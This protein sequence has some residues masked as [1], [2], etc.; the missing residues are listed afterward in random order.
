LRFSSLYAAAAISPQHQRRAQ[1]VTLHRNVNSDER[2]SPLESLAMPRQPFLPFILENRGG[3]LDVGTH[4]MQQRPDIELLIAN[5]LM[6]WPHAEAQMAILL[7]YLLGAQQ[8]EAVLAVFHSL[9]RSSAQ[10]DAISEAARFTISE[11]DQELLSAILSAHKR[12]ESERNAL[13]HGH[14]GTYSLLPDGIV[15]MD[16][17]TF[18]DVKARIDLGHQIPSQHFL[19]QLYDRTY[20]YKAN[21]ISRTFDDIKD[22]ADIWDKFI[23][24]LRVGQTLPLSSG[25]Y[26]QLC[27]RPR[28]AQELALLRREKTP[29]A[30]PESPQPTSGLTP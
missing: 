13:A 2:L 5:C 17:K 30:Q 15:W 22:I 29:L 16:T 24:Y 9:R 19:E 12:I 6:A 4:A 11:T 25:L 8:S 18:V 10:R 26:R 28:I 20:I 21:D 27:D 3:K 23:Q 7:A 1:S 14:F